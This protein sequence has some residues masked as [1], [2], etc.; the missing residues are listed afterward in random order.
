MTEFAQTLV[1]DRV[2]KK[3]DFWD[4]LY[5]NILTDIQQN[6]AIYKKFSKFAF[7]GSKLMIIGDVLNNGMSLTQLYNII[8]MNC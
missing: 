8:H 5:E 4:K 3:D 7:N 6:L 2:Q 1:W